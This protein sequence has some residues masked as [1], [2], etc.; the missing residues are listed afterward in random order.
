MASLY[1]RTRSPF[2]WIKYRTTSGVIRYEST[3]FRIGTV[4][5]SRKAK[6]LLHQRQMEE[7]N[8]PTD[9]ALKTKMSTWVVKFLKARH[10]SSPRSLEKYLGTWKVLETF[11]DERGVQ[12]AE[13]I[14]RGHCIDYIEARQLG[15]AGLGPAS[16]NTALHDL[17]ILRAVLYEA[18][19][20]GYIVKNPAARLGISPDRPKEKKEFTAEQIA[21]VEEKLK[22]E[23]E[24][25][26]IAWAIAIRQGCRIAE[27]S[28][29]L[30]AVNIDQGTITFRLKG[31]RHHVTMLHPELV[32]LFERFKRE[33]RKE[34]YP[35]STNLSRDF[36]RFFRRKDVNLRDHSFHCTRVTAI[37]RL[38][39]SGRVSEQMAMRFIGHST[40]AVHAVYQKLGALDL[41]PCVSELSEK[42]NLS[43][44][45]PGCFPARKGRARGLS[46]SRT[47]GRSQRT[48]LR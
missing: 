10:S 32:P 14:T 31:G 29:P 7:L 39:R 42:R 5:E 45:S 11:F 16:K 44:E 41:G 27:T 13:Q 8:S 37:T 46:L 2:W 12:R 22:S 26:Q 3:G 23:S 47:G 17:R 43:S 15:L 35:F 24:P 20:R 21:L 6:A 38:A 36:T 18:E 48:A 1:R 40:Q 30:S 28:L 4:S 25:M 19:R 34:T 9:P 33:G